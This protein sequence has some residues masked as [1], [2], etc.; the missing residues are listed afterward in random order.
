MAASPQFDEPWRGRDDKTETATHANFQ[1]I[2]LACSREPEEMQMEWVGT[3]TNYYSTC[4]ESLFQSALTVAEF[5]RF[6]Y[7]STLRSSVLDRT[8]WEDPG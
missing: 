4:D 3:E 7:T 8:D 6:F 2:T 5:V 1:A